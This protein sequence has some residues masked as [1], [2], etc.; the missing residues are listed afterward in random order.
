MS[1]SL[2]DK[3]I[4]LSSELSKTH[5]IM[6]SSTKLLNFVVNDMLA[7]AEINRGRFRQNLSSF[8][9]QQAVEEVY[10]V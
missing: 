5:Q 6:H 8:N 7:Y 1:D 9:I 2:K 3:L 10:R 4:D